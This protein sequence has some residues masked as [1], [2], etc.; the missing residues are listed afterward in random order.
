MNNKVAADDWADVCTKMT[1]ASVSISYPITTKLSKEEQLYSNRYI[2]Y[3]RF[4]N[5]K[6][7]STV[8]SFGP[9]GNNT[10]SLGSLP[11]TATM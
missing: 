2:V 9:L 1:G 7:W 11:V 5:G 6:T 3:P 8:D 10:F 4:P